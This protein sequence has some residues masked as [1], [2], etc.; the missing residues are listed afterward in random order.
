MAQT[1][2][3]PPDCSHLSQVSNVQTTTSTAWTLT[4]NIKINIRNSKLVQ[5]VI[6]HTFLH[7]NMTW[8]ILFYSIPHWRGSAIYAYFLEKGR[9]Q[10]AKHN[11]SKHP[12]QVNTVNNTSL[13]TVADN[14]PP[15]PTQGVLKRNLSKDHSPKV[16]LE[17]LL[18]EKWESME[19][20]TLVSKYGSAF[21]KM[22]SWRRKNWFAN[23]NVL[24]QC[25]Q[26]FFKL[27]I[28]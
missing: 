25:V 22:T 1:I 15:V 19:R 26:D 23:V 3:N 2:R 9:P 10:C 5:L 17:V 18:W 7:W 21:V 11:S 24:C 4:C 20:K 12:G 28:S 6:R 8:D 14:M 13:Q 27:R 16:G